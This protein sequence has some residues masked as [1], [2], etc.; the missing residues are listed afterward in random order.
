M[1]INTI[2]DNIVSDGSA[3]INSTESKKSKETRMAKTIIIKPPKQQSQS[4]TTDAKNKPKIEV[5]TRPAIRSKK[6]NKIN[7]MNMISESNV[8]NRIDKLDKFERSNNTMNEININMTNI[9]NNSIIR[10]VELSYTSNPK[11]HQ[12][13][14][15]NINDSQLQILHNSGI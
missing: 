13:N 1:N 2:N 3:L 8:V 12:I 15:T 14:L 10:E 4:C 11:K 7:E 6:L 5:K 9:M